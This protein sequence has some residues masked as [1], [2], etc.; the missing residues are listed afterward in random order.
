MINTK[1]KKIEEDDIDQ[2]LHHL[3]NISDD[4]TKYYYVLR[5]LQKMKDN[6]KASIIVKDKNGN[7]PGSTKEKIEVIE[8]YFK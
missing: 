4:N 1:L 7:C 3:E 6:K 5:D 2:K 8:Q